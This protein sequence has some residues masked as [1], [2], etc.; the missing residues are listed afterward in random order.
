MGNL[1]IWIWGFDKEN[2][3][4]HEIVFRYQNSDV[5]FSVWFLGQRDSFP[6]S[7]VRMSDKSNNTSL[8]RVYLAIDP[9]LDHV[10]TLPYSQQKQ[11][12]L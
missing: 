3:K 12:H 7:I 9:K 5:M 11:L 1:N 8:K 6:V 2:A 4:K 10:T